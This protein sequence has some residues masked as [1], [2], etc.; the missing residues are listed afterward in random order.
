M[1]EKCFICDVSLPDSPAPVTCVKCELNLRFCHPDH[2]LL[3]SP[4]AL[5]TC[6]PFTITTDPRYGR[7]L[8]AGRDIA[9][10]ELVIAETALAWGPHHIRGKL[11]CTELSASA[12]STRD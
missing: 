11:G 10:G 3:H 12:P 1:M 2:L 9:P 7:L 6:L 8:V 4:S 5:A